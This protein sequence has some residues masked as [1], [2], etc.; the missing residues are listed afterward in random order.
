MPNINLNLKKK[1]FNE[2][3]FP[4]LL[5]YRNRY[6]VYYG[7]AGSGKSV[8]LGQKLVVKACRSKRKVLV[9]RKFGTTLKDS[10][11]QLIIDTL[12]KW[13]IYEY[14]KVNLSTYTITL[15][16]ES[17][18]LF[19]GL[20]DSEKIKSI[21][22][23]TDIWCEEGTELSED[24]FTQ[25][26]LRLRASVPHL[27]LFISFNP[28]SKT[29]WVY[30]RWFAEGAIYDKETTKILHTTYKDNRFLPQSY[31]KALEEKA[32]TNFTYYRIY[33]LGEFASLDKLVYTNWRVEEFDHKSIVGD[34]AI[35][36]DF[37]FVNDISAL[38]ASVID[39]ANKRIYIFREWG[40]TNK[41]NEEIAAI[42]TS[43]GFAKSVIIADCAEQ[44][45]IE[46]LKRKGITRI[47]ACSKGKDSILHGIQHLQQYELIV[48][49]SCGGV[50][51]EFENYSWQKDNKTNEY[52]NKPIDTFNHYLDALRYSI[53]IKDSNNKLKTISKVSMNAW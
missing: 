26:D 7:G 30:K 8:F 49:P 32:R 34:L 19:K 36:L 52:V 46:E 13:Q 3:Y 40:D 42:I 24:E 17:M 5:D 37:G 31:V 25:L 38:I 45:S 11:F 15:P 9:I 51:T 21:T 35:G 39:E 43:L 53:Q 4:S 48:H 12:K 10:V 44:K 16:N 28:V 22:D 23:I 41:T 14:C 29:N 6:E 1:L 2:V 18:F 33:A 20:D 47:K 27:Q 50:I